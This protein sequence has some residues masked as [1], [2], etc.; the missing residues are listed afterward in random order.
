[1]IKNNWNLIGKKAVVTGAANGIGLAI[2]ELFLELGAQVLMVD[3]SQNALTLEKNRLIKQ[4]YLVDIIAADISNIREQDLILAK[5][6]S[7]FGGVDILVNNVG[8]NIRKSTL[9]YTSEDFHKIITVNLEAA[10]NLSRKLYPLLKLSKSAS[11]INM[12]SIA[13]IIVNRF[14]GPLYS[15]SKAALE[16][17]SNYLAV[18]WASSGIRV[19]SVHPGSIRTA[20]SIEVLS[21]SPDM[22]TKIINAIPLGRI[23]DPIE[24][25]N[26]VG[27]LAMPAS[28][29]ITAANLVIDGGFTKLGF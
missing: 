6:N 23:A 12:S 1:M 7:F 22:E 29:Y 8:I 13:S 21:R 5:A 25:A 10:F 15:M 18:E 28:S 17:M 16:Q 14:S 27:F 4:N 2:T 3:I 9:E 20:L 26:V 24:V 11:I 19:N